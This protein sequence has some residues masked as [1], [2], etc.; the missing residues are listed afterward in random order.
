MPFGS[1]GKPWK[2]PR[3]SPRQAQ[4][5]AALAGGAPPVN[6]WPWGRQLLTSALPLAMSLSLVGAA[7]IGLFLIGPLSPANLAPLVYLIPVM[8]AATRWGTWP[9]IVAAIASAAA[10]DFFF[11]PPFYSFRLDD[12]QAAINLLVFLLVALISG[13]LMSRLRRETET[14]RR[15]EHELQY[16][17]RFSRRL[18]S[19]HT[20]ADLAE[21]IQDYLSETFG[22]HTAFFFPVSVTV[23]R[24][25]MVGAVP[26]IV[27]DDAASMMKPGGAH[28][29]TIRDHDDKSL[30]LLRAV[31]SGEATH[32]VIAVD[33]GEE[34]RA[35]VDERTR[36]VE[37]ILAEA[38]QT[39]QRLDIGGA[40]E[41]A[42]HRSKDQLLRD[43]FHGDLS[44]ELRSPLAAIRGSASVL[45]A[46]PSIRDEGR[47]FPLVSTIT[48]E[49]D[50]LDSFIGNLLNATRVSAS[51]IRPHL[52][53]ADPR[54]I[55]NAA[56]RRRSRPLA[57]H[58]VK[59]RFDNDLPMVNVDSALAEEACGQL[60]ENAAKYSP[61]GSTISVA[62]SAE[63][64]H[65]TFSISDQGAGITAEERAQLGRRSFRGARHREAVAG[66]GLGF[67]IASTFVAANDGT[68]DITSE[69]EGRG[70]TA[71]IILPE[72]M[73]DEDAA[74]SAD[75]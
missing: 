69:G 66:A 10:A 46:M 42:S 22:R 50:R 37:A 24:P 53:C 32:G 58:A 41:E 64:G 63:K 30:W 17:Y 23:S 28:S 6:A 40:L 27:Q 14:L 8:I 11:Y 38:S 47:A 70:T 9:A 35:G 36:R 12:S 2:L 4:A 43:A 62:V 34:P 25:V 74:G 13:D 61:S 54:D 3:P 31:V 15:R 21:A 44:H 72:A 5:N 56:I 18:A 29:R 67:W 60:L 55:I 20:V 71:S 7:T 59:V 65:V 1:E 19:C 52:S 48:D 57:A 73:I 51:D 45:E 26:A 33:I 75:E 16:L 49:A 39:L 68:I